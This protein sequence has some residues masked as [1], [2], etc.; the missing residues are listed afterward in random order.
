[1]GGLGSDC[2]GLN[3][4]ADGALCFPKGCRQLLR[5]AA[6]GPCPGWAPSSASHLGWQWWWL[7]KRQVTPPHEVTASGREAVAT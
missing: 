5:P 2:P 6:L 7:G 3:F 4:Q 1:M